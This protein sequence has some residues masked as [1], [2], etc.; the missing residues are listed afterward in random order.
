MKSTLLILS[1]L[2]GVTFT[3]NAQLPNGSIAPDF[4]LTDRDGNEHRLYDYLNEGKVVFVEFFACHCPSCWAYHTA[5]TLESLYQT[6]GPNG[7]DQIMVLML[8]HDPNNGDDHFNG[9]HWYTQGDWVTG[10]SIPMFNVEGADRTVFDDYNMVYYPMVYKVCPD[11]TTEL[12][13]TSQSVSDLYQAAD[14]CPGTLSIDKETMSSIDVKIVEGNLILSD[15]DGVNTLEV[16]NATGQQVYYSESVESDVIE[17][18]K[19][20]TGVLFVKISHTNGSEVH[21]V[22]VN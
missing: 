17:L 9:N 22:F 1:L 7:T 11:R 8:E 2:M 20:S 14:D 3:A 10:N 15:V 13:S 16:V 12:M 6:Y 5:G 21:K 19:E 4:T 18:T